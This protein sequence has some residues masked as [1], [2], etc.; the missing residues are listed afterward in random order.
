MALVNY[1]GWRLVASSVLPIDETTI[2]YGSPNSRRTVHADD[3]VLND[4][5]QQAAS[6]LNLK[7]P[8]VVLCACMFDVCNHRRHPDVP[9]RVLL[10]LLQGHEISS[11][12]GTKR[13]FIHAP[14]DVEGHLGK[15]GRYY[16]LDTHR[17]M[18]PTIALLKYDPAAKSCVALFI[19]HDTST[20]SC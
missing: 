3:P 9:S 14:G 16:L 19:H 18:P 12:D 8:A 6:H 13:V 5:M 4:I 15:D 2:A 1:R 7:V 20:L 17:V 10:P 11:R